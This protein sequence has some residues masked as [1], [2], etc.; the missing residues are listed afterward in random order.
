LNEK[1]QE[2][3]LAAAEFWSGLA[4][5]QLEEDDVDN[6]RKESISQVMPVLGPVLLE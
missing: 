3:A 5:N 4:L 2:V 6:D 1:D